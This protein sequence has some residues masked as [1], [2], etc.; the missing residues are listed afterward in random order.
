[1]ESSVATSF[2]KLGFN[3]S[4]LWFNQCFEWCRSENPNYSRSKVLDEIKRQWFMTDI[5]EDGVQNEQSIIEESWLKARKIVI[6][7]NICLQILSAIDIGKSAYSQLQEILKADI[8]NTLI[9]SDSDQKEFKAAWEPKG[10]RVLKICFT[11]GHRKIY[12]IEHEPISSLKYPLTPG[13]KVRLNGP[14]ICRRGTILLTP[15]N[16]YTLS[17]LGIEDL[18]TEFELKTI[19]ADKIGKEDVGLVQVENSVNFQQNQRTDNRYLCFS[20]TSI[21]ILKPNRTSCS[22]CNSLR[23]LLILDCIILIF[24]DLQMQYLPGL[25]FRRLQIL[26]MT[27]TS[28]TQLKCLKMI[29]LN[30]KP[31]PFNKSRENL[32]F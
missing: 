22:N 31:L 7:Q 3:A 17:D 8:A 30:L 13:M 2:D 9:S 12:G 20:F 29:L 21:S 15:K 11:D 6:K 5:R 18:E 19:L 23:L 1:M 10:N 14:L 26:R 28:S 16:L 24:S 27:M 4:R 32:P 25:K